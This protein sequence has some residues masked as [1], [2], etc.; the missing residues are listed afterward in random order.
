[1]ITFAY[2]SEMKES[3]SKKERN[4]I[5]GNSHL[6]RSNTREEILAIVDIKKIIFYEKTLL[7]WH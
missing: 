4:L 3:V 1:M 2:S 7:E 6:L 5:L